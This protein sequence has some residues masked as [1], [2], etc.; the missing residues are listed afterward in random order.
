V[1]GM[2]GDQVN[3]TP[4]HA[5][6]AVGVFSPQAGAPATAASV[7]TTAAP[8]PATAT[9]GASGLAAP[10]SPSSSEGNAALA[11]ASGFSAAANPLAGRW[12]FLMDEPMDHV[13]RDVGLHPP[14]GITACQAW[15][16]IGAACRPA[17]KCVPLLSAINKHTP[18]KFMMPANGQGAFPS[19]VHVGTYYVMTTAKVNNGAMCWN[20]RTEL[21]PGANSLTLDRRNGERLK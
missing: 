21:K 5:S 6:C 13:A 10:A 18:E 17:T 12:I 20:V 4:S 1:S 2:T 7:Q 19:G 9:H 16:A 14:A 11:V 3:F 15:A 8:P